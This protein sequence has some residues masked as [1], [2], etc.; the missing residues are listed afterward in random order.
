MDWK[1]LIL[2]RTQATGVQRGE[3]IQSLWSGFGEIF[4][5]HL[6]PASMGTLIV[7]H[8][9][10]F[11]AG[12]HPRG[13]GTDRSTQRKLRSYEVETCWYSDWGA[14]LNDVD[15]CRIPKCFGAAAHGDERWILLEDLDAVGYGERRGRLDVQTAIPCIRWLANFHGAFLGKSP[16]GLWPVGTYWHLDTRPDEYAVMGEGPL[17]EAARKLDAMLSECEYQTFVHGDAKVAN[18]CFSDSCNEVAA[19]DFQYVG[20]GCGM[21]DVAYFLGSCFD[22]SQ[23]EQ[24][25]PQLLNEYFVHLRN[26]VSGKTIA[27]KEVDA[28]RLESQWRTLFAPAWTDFH[29]F[30]LG[31]MPGH[32][33][34]HEYTQQLTRE[35]LLWL[36]NK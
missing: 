16:E 3:S 6:Q 9:A 23:C 4:R 8:I 28:D 30:L 15:E 22:P 35:T 12:A 5:V 7:K 25:V 32:H 2:E 1:R 34:N 11:K 31:W 29:R 17:K 24:W 10:P 33:K 14:T 26:A 21:K 13:W 36:A 27:G 18:F 19:V 20:G